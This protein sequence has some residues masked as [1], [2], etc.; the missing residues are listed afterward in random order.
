MEKD[1][2]QRARKLSDLYQDYNVIQE[3]LEEH[4]DYVQCPHC[5]GKVSTHCLLTLEE[6]KEIF[7]NLSRQAIWKKLNRM[8]EFGWF[9]KIDLR[10]ETFRIKKYWHPKIK[11]K[12]K[13]F[14]WRRR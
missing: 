7:P 5:N 13:K 6:Y 9:D 12:I 8:H 2:V 10:R 3:Y 4:S 1:W 14:V 11:N